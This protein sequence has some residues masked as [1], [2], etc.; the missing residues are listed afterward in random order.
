MRNT[1]GNPSW[2]FPLEGGTGSLGKGG[3]EISLGP[4]LGKGGEEIPLGPPLGKG[5]EIPL[6][7]LLAGETSSLG[8]RE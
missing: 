2:S 7:F 6:V 8:N 3:E 4:P 5:E 1:R